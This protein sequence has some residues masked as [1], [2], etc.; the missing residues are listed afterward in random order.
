MLVL[1][2]VSGVGLI[3]DDRTLVGA[4]IWLKPLKFSISLTIYTVT[5]AW[6]I[7]LL[8]RGRKAATRLGTV[9][10]VAAFIEMAIIVGQVVRGRQSHFN[11]ATAL[12]A[13]LFSTM[14]V[15]IVVV[16]LAT[17]WIGVL[18][19][20]Q[21]IG[22]RPTAL[23]IRSGVVIA[24]GGL[25]TGFLMTNPTSDQL[26][27]MDSAPPTLVG[28][29][30]VGVPD[31]GAGLPILGWSTEGGDL[32][33]GHFVGMHA[34]QALPLLAFLLVLAARRFARLRDELL[35]TRVVLIFAGAHAAITLLV[36]WQ[37]LRGQ[38]LLKPDTLTLSA[39]LAIAAAAMIGLVL[40]FTRP[41][42][43]ETAV[44]A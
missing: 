5:M 10:A 32:R 4:P 31:G 23:A 9:I 38:P 1:A 43:V 22:D 42:R 33:V 27:K 41:A 35:R 13:A 6:L 21:R 19:M 8:T 40:S 18:L 12:D 28:A 16:W 37:A 36:I 14:G 39:L 15:T 25:A 44:A 20:I 11:V 34:L 29:H 2:V 7:S 30:S 26:A 3:V 24:L 17:L